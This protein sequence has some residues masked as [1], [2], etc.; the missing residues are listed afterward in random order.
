MLKSTNYD[1]LNN[2]IPLLY[3]SG[4]YSPYV[5]MLD[6]ILLQENSFISRYHVED[7]KAILKPNQITKNVS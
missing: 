6:K 7:I 1:S 5:K 3:E 4:F 2:R